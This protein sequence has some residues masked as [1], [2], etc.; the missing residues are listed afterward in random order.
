MPASIL[1]ASQTPVAN[2]QVIQQ[3]NLILKNNLTAVNQYFLHARMMKHMGFMKLADYE[4]KESIQQMKYADRL[5]ERILF[6]SGIPDMQ[7]FG[8]LNIGKSVDEILKCDLEL[9]EVSLRD[10]K[11]V[12]ALCESR[13]DYASADTLHNILESAEE[14]VQFIRTQL[15][16]VDT[17][18]LPQYLQTQV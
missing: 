4:Y 2:N 11:S 12:I 13:D 1:Q 15:N 8:N 17:I 10:L 16:L 7:E 5:V 3:L 6:L 18:G 14:H 9:E